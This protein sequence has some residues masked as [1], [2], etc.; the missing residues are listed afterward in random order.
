MKYKV[1]DLVKCN[2]GYS[3]DP[4][5]GEVCEIVDGRF[6]KVRI[7]HGKDNL[8]IVNNSWT[9][10]ECELEKVGETKLSKSDIKTAVEYLENIETYPVCY[11]LLPRKESFMQKLSNLPQA[12]R[13]AFDKDQK[14]LYRAGYIDENGKWTIT[15]KQEADEDMRQK[16]LTDNRQEFID[17]ANEAIELAKEEECE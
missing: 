8:F 14:V 10:E 9:Y 12:I 2:K 4:S 15:A 6:L 5:E 11:G 13:R 7:T 1:G 16:Y 3:F 17:R